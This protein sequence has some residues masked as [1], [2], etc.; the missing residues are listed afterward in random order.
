MVAFSLFWRYNSKR[1]TASELDAGKEENAMDHQ[2]TLVI[3]AA[4]MGSRFGGLKQLTPVDDEGHLII[5]YS[6]FDAYRAGFRRVAFI[7]KEELKEEFHE[8][9][10]S[11]M[12]PYFH[13][14]YVCQKLTTLPE[15]F[16]PPADRSKPWG[17]A[18]AVGCCRGIVKG[19]MAVINADDYYGPTAFQ[20]IYDF[21]TTNT[22]ETQY[23][24]VGYRLRNTVTENGS[25][26]RGV[27]QVENGLLQDV[28]ERT[29]IFKRGEDAAYTEDG[30]T[31]V[32]LRGSSI[33]SMNFWGFSKRIL[34]SIWDGFPAFLQKG[35]AENPLKCEYYLPSVVSSELKAGTASV[36]VLDC[37]ETWYG[38]T[39]KEDLVSVRDALAQ[40]REASIYP[41]KLWE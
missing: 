3:M 13:I 34:E 18:H 29:K 36:R 2:P 31:F 9:I 24:M 40:K 8:A 27:C 1:K 7:V 5:D 21:L 10:G 37:D 17:T 30:Q 19:A 14:D 33:V 11:R 35:L 22:D 41:K 12:A 25:V 39:Y 6:L 26:A 15:G 23:A 20:K 38:M 16:T 4:G 28:V 32:P